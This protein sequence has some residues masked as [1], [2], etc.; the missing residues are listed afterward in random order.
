MQQQFEWVILGEL[1]GEK[2]W[3]TVMRMKGGNAFL[4]PIYEELWRNKHCLL[5]KGG[6]KFG[7]RLPNLSKRA[8]E[9]EKTKTRE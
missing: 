3:E 1:R 4:T 7:A 5:K 8:L 9:S 6:D 2:A